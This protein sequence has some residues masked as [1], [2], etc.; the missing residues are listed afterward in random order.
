MN[1]VSTRAFGSFL[2]ALR[3]KRVAVETIVA[4][5]TLTAAD[6]R[7]AKKRIDWQDFLILMRNFRA[8]FDD[9]ELIEIGRSYYRAPTLRFAFVVARMLFS[10]MDFYRW[11]NKPRDGIG[12]QMF[13]CIV[14]SQRDL[15]DHEIEVDLLLRDGYEM[16]WDF[17]IVAIGNF[18]EMPVLLGSPPAKVTLTRL[19]HGGRF[20]IDVQNRTPLL[21][22]LRRFFT[23]PFTAVSAA[24][25]LKAAHETLLERYEELE[26]ART[27]L[28]RQAAQLR[29]AHSVNSLVQRDLD[30]HVT[31]EAAATALVSQAGFA[32]ATLEVSVDGEA[33][34]AE[35]GAAG[36]AELTRTLTGQ[37]GQVLGSLTVSVDGRSDA[38]E[39][40][41]LLAFV[42][43]MV[44]MAVHNAVSYHNLETYRANL[45]KVVDERTVDLRSARDDLA[46]T[47]VQ[48]QEVQ[49]SRDV[50]FANI[51]HEIRTPLS[52]IILAAGDIEVSAGA[53]LDE[54][55]RGNLMSVV[56]LVDE[57]LLLAAGEQTKLRLQP[58][59]VDVS[60]LVEGLVSTWR[61]AA[62]AAGLSLTCT[63]PA[64]AAAFV[65]PTALDRIVTNLVSN[66]VKFTPRGG[67]IGVALI[68]QG[69][70]LTITVSDTGVGIDDELA[71]RLF[72]RFERSAQDHGKSG[73]GIG[74][75]LVKQLVEAHGGGVEMVR[76]PGG[77]AEFRITLPRHLAMV[78]AAPAAT[79][80]AA[81]RRLSPVDFGVLQ[82]PARLE[83]VTRPPGVSLGTILV[84]EDDPGL[85]AVVVRLLA[86]EY[87]VI[88]ASDGAAALELAKLHQ[89]HLLVTD[90]QMPGMNGIELAERFRA[91]TNDRLAPVI[92]MSAVN[93]L[94]TRVRGLDAGA[95]D[96]IVKPFDL[97]ELRARVHAQ[98]RMRD[99]AVRL[100]QAEQLS[101]LG[102]LSAGLAHE[103]RNP[104]NGII[105]AIRPLAKLLPT[106]LT[107]KSSAVGQLLEVASGCADQIAF[108]SRQLLNFRSNGELEL[109]QI[110]LADLVKRTLTLTQEALA[111]VQVRVDLAFDGAVRCAPQLMMQ[112]L[113]NLIDNAAQAAKSGGWV[114]VVSRADGQTISIEV[115]DSGDGVPLELRDRVFEPFFTT[116][117]PGIGTGLGLPLARDIVHR[118]GG[119]LEIR[120][121]GL[122]SV[123]AVDLPQR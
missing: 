93:D 74:L 65:D 63:A 42:A 111:G 16:C 109:R 107:A 22:K 34:K 82:A 115:G 73:S 86:D 75:S 84:A 95:V 121:R 46:A 99:L 37:G 61:P 106:E 21:T 25:E 15:S 14:P 118:H 58:E 70:A 87:T 18:E 122:K 119:R 40:A 5:S 6:L 48:L 117:P 51:S 112:V 9:D 78:Q 50:F 113:T 2:R 68:D 69:D 104:A 120:D 80:A 110:S 32:S 116:K 43:P 23:R 71:G 85:S 30:L 20:Y 33:H 19:P 102:T 53:A 49:G 44:S 29:I 64:N 11:A 92:I 38:G 81:V 57:L 13:T 24:R 7:N 89:P 101:A 97:R 1:E 77:G 100:H 103:L 66:A 76:P 98:F 108:L 28:D 54:R 114:E 26:Q 8:H 96:Y 72:G 56:G 90:V 55:A 36:G 35:R 91:A 52:L 79:P 105:N 45:E 59:I 10:P 60:S 39:R 94:G 123:F 31:L 4:G 83:P 41:E 17:F 27:T 47:V 62:E 88:A 67:S 12:N 3:K